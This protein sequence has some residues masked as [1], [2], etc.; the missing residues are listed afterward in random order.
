MT[1]YWRIVPASAFSVMLHSAPSRPAPA[2]EII[3]PRIM[4]QCRLVSFGQIEIDGRRFDHDVVIEEGRVRRRKKGPSKRR[5][6]AFGHTP[7]SRDE[8][9]PW[10]APLLIIGT[11]ASGQLPITDDL[12]RAAERRSVEVVARPTAEACEL[13]TAAD[14]KSV[15]AILHVTC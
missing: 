13:L 1:P 10:S 2:G 9:I 11:G 15:A 6:A 14:A 5:R 12:Y 4:M 3:R 7:L 8:A